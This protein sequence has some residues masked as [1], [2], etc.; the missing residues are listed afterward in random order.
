MLDGEPRIKLGTYK[1]C[2]VRE[3]DEIKNA[4]AG[5][6]TWQPQAVPAYGTGWEEFVREIT[7][8]VV[9]SKNKMIKCNIS[10]T[11]SQTEEK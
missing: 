11:D 5:P 9:S 8:H 1:R 7:P 3:K 2:P 10:R 4:P 6:E